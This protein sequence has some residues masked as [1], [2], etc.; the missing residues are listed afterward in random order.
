MRRLWGVSVPSERTTYACDLCRTEWATEGQAEDCENM[1]V[2]TPAD[3][4]VERVFFY[5]R[6]APRHSMGRVRPEPRLDRLG[7]PDAI[8]IRYPD[9][10]TETFVYQPPRGI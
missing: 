8:Q 10:R 4:E 3:C 5:Q 2:I 6:N 9:G 7:R 1:H